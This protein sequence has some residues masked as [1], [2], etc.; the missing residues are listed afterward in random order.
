MC[1]NLAKIYNQRLDNKFERRIATNAMLV[2]VE[3]VRKVSD[4]YV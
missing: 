3:I 4:I 1:I 2:N